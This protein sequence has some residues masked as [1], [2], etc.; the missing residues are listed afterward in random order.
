L[1]REGAVGSDWSFAEKAEAAQQAHAPLTRAHNRIDGNGGGSSG[2]VSG[3][4]VDGED[5]SFGR[6]SGSLASSAHSEADR[7]IGSAALHKEPAAIAEGPVESAAS[8]GGASSPLC[9]AQETRW[10]TVSWADL[11]EA[12]SEWLVCVDDNWE[13]LSTAACR[14]VDN[15]RLDVAQS[16]LVFARRFLDLNCADFGDTGASYASVV[17]FV[18]AHISIAL[19]PG[20]YLDGI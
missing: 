2:L 17:N 16:C 9:E 13:P 19:G 8:V 3:V 6:G 7:P 5:Y 15:G 11:K 18:Q 1:V 14:L 12:L 4:T 10:A 20:F